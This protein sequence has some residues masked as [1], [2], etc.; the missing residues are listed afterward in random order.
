[1]INRLYAMYERSKKILIFLVV[2]FLAI[3]IAIGVI[4][5]IISISG[6]ISGGKLR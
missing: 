3:E 1:M 6:D 4:T 5:T 2:I